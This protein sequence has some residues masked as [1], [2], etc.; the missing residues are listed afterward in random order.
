[1]FYEPNNLAKGKKTRPKTSSGTKWFGPL[2]Q[3][4]RSFYEDRMEGVPLTMTEWN[5][6]PLNQCICLVCQ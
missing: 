4:T 2:C 5:T 1:M 6:F 3:N